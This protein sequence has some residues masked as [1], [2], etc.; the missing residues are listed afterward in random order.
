MAIEQGALQ[1]SSQ[2]TGMMTH[3]EHDVERDQFEP[4]VSEEDQPRRHVLDIYMSSLIIR[5]LYGVSPRLGVEANFPMRLTLVSA[6]FLNKDG[7]EI[8]DFASIHHRSEPIWGL[9]DID[10]GGRLQL[11]S[12]DD[13]LPLSVTSKLGLTLPTGSIEPDPYELGRLGVDHQHMFFGTGT[14]DPIADMNVTYNTDWLLM[15]GWLYGRGALYE[16][17]YGYR[18]R[19]MLNGGLGVGSGF[20]LETWRF[21]L[22]GEGRHEE[23]ALWSGVPARNSGM[24]EL[25]VSGGVQWTLFDRWTISGT[26][27]APVYTYSRGGQ[28]VTMPNVTIGLAYTN[29]TSVEMVFEDSETGHDHGGHEDGEH[30]HGGHEDGHDD[31]FPA[32]RPANGDVKDAALN[33]NTFDLDDVIVPNKVTV[34]DYWATW[35]HACEHVDEALFELAS[36]HENLAIRKVEV[37]TFETEVAKEHLKDVS[38]LPVVWIF[39]SDGKLVSKMVGPEIEALRKE[40]L[41]V[42]GESDEDSHAHHHSDSE[43]DHG[44]H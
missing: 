12:P 30:D 28:V 37:P 6:A 13:I 2:L 10:I 14:F 38:A 35:C 16:N 3:V 42:L 18:G 26:L 43:S 8:D 36:Q 34:I 31:D 21:V 19:S 40:V 7:E 22:Q 27:R 44:H 24:T 41:D 4:G 25:S 39:D 20:G 32:S 11:W 15:L 17:D 29:P 1:I 5:T 9:G 23:P 33:G